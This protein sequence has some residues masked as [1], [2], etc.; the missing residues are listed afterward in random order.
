PR[1]AKHPADRW[2]SLVLLVLFA[3]ILHPDTDN[4]AAAIAQVALYVAVF[5][6]IYWVPAFVTSRRRL[7]RVLA[8]LL[9]C[10]GLNSV[11]G[12]LQ[13]Y[14][15]DRWMPAEF[16][17]TFAYN[18]NLLRASTYIGPNGRRIIRPPGLFDT[19]GAVCG[20]GTVAAL[21]G[22]IFGLGK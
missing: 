9:I 17:S 5:S 16:S 7:I 20:A 22:L 8:I 11:V 15:P 2:L 21:L 4:L 12:V 18:P 10:N 6:P 3:M 19:P 13:V 1:T 14:D